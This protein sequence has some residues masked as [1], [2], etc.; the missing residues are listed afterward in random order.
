MT[1]TPPTQATNTDTTTDTAPRH[2]EIATW[3][4]EEGLRGATQRQLLEDFCNK[5]AAAGVPLMRAHVAQSA[6]H[7]VY[8]GIG[9]DWYRQD[10]TVTEE[11]YQRRQEPVEQWLRSP[12][13]HMLKNELTELRV[14]LAD[15]SGPAE[16][17]IFDLIKGHGGTD[18]FACATLFESKDAILDPLKPPQGML[19]SWSSDGADGFSDSDIDL[20]RK[21]LPILG[22]ALK[23]ASSRRTAENLLSVYLGRDAGRRVLSGEIQRGSL[24]SIRA[25]IWYFDLQGF[26]KLSE[27]TSA[28]LMIAMLNDYFGAVVKVVEGNGGNV[29]KFMGDGLLAIF[30]PGDDQAAC[31]SAIAACTQLHNDIE[32]L[33]AQRTTDALP[34]TSFTLAMHLGEVLYGNIGAEERLDFTVVGP[35]VNMSARI[36]SMCRPLEQNIILSSAVAE[37]A[38][39][40]TNEIVS[41]G[42]YMLRGVPDPQEL[43]TLTSANA[44]MSSI[45]A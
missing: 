3:I 24:E 2:R 38:S 14:C 15:I 7:P 36:Q 44:S 16:F 26:T 18:Y 43:F 13:F 42:R 5:V 41:L 23:S 8:G 29:L 34:Q 40:D 31:R 11:T 17:P 1:K 12:M 20:I 45:S 35:A 22:L 25:V 30:N 37:I 19:T 21:L 32:V 33:N 28:E 39:R 10:T 9:F 4:V 6:L 27:T